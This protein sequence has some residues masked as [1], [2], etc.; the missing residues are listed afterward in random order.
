MN[1]SF[2]FSA[3]PWEYPGKAAWTFLSTPPDVTAAIS[4]LASGTLRR[5]FGSVKVR[6]SI[7]MTTWTTSIF[8]DT[9]IGTYLL[10]I[11][12]EVR[13]REGITPTTNCEVYLEC[14]L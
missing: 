11:K 7:G 4:D 5:G 3:T 2:T 9:K 12:R 6:V 1:P 14:L 10:P 8:P 13:I